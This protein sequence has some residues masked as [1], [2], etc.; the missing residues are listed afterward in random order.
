LLLD[1]ATAALDTKSERVVQEALDNASE[2]RTT[3]AIAHRL[4]TIKNADKIVVMAKGKI[5]E[6]GTHDDLIK[7]HGVYHG[8]VQAQELTEQAAPFNQLSSISKPDHHEKVELDGD[9]LDL[10]RTATK[11]VSVRSEE[12]AETTFTTSELLRFS[13]QMNSGEHALMLLGFLLS[14]LAGANPAIQ[15]IFLGNSINSF[16]SPSTSTGG[17]GILFWCWMFFMLGIAIWIFY[18]FQ[19]ATLSKASA[20]LIARI[21]E[22]AFGAILRQDMEFFDGE[23]VTSGSLTTFLSSEANRLAGLS[24][25]TLGT[26]ISA[27]ATV[28]IAIA[29]A[30]SFGWKLALVSSAC[31]PLMLACG[32]YRF[33]ALTRMDKR[34]KETNDA[35][36]FASEAASSIRTVASLSLENHL[37]VQ[38][39]EKLDAQARGNLKFMN[40]SS[41]LF[42]TSQGL[43]LFIF[44]LVFWYGGGLLTKM[45][46]TVLQFFIV[47][48]AI[49]NGAQSAGAVFSFAPDMGEARDAAI[50]LKSFFTRVPKIDHWSPA[51][52]RVDHLIGKIELR[53]V[54]FA[55]PGRPDHRILRGVSLKAEPGQFVA[56]VGAS[57]SGKSTVMAL[58]ERFYDPTSGAVLV[59][60]VEL[61]DYN[62]QSYRKQLAIVSQETTLYTGTIRDN[63]LAD[64][65]EVDEEAIVQACKDANIYEFIVSFSEGD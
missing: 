28:I 22:Q 3:I 47:Y 59:D 23:T 21:R 64:E 39:H 65:D 13:W 24:G 48:S 33:H 2:G 46:Y 42:A 62:L 16:F 40:V 32:Y 19:G 52:K 49:I 11:P 9:A 31:I 17:H 54:R 41:A 35:A 6:Q 38:Y 15:A 58:L 18:F 7:A 57:G 56:L 30:C 26:I 12:T 29:V 8:L 36:S 14:V 25:S 63:I 55:Y 43:S 45:E 34:T 53:N 50:V 20:E 60:D 51:G 37:L 5:V 4:S 1:E 27:I 44:A 61:K 10:T